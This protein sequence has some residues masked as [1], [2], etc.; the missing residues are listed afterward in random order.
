MTE[1]PNPAE[2]QLLSIFKALADA[3][4]LKIISLLAGQPYTVE[5]LAS[6][7]ELRP[8]TISHHLARLA[9]AGLVSARAESY[10]NIYSLE[11]GA[12][13]GAARSLLTKDA[14][15][16]FASAVDMDAFDR[17]VLRDFSLPNG[18]LKA[19]PAQRKKREAVLREL[20]KD[21]EYGRRYLESEVVK[22]LR[23]YH[24][25]TAT[26]RRE[27]VGYHVL[28]R[29]GGYYWRPDPEKE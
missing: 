11:Q 3:T 23:K 19:I 10:Y 1:Q 26:L 29:Q 13:E 24:D 20:V 5:Q 7:L 8:S 21:F 2:A 6:L 12:L 17:K 18:R 25:D 14:L 16:N 4:R 15:P 28:D 27:M 9:E 22:I